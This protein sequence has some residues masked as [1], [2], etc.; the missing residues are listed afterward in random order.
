MGFPVRTATFS[1]TLGV[2]YRAVRGKHGSEVTAVDCVESR[3]RLVRFGKE[4]YELR[5]KP[6]N[7]GPN[8]LRAGPLPQTPKIVLIVDS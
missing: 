6:K 5:E 3:C 4:L 1:Y 2:K 7:K 8:D